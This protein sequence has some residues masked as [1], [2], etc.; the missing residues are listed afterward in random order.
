MK[1]KIFFMCVVAVCLS[2]FAIGETTYKVAAN[3]CGVN[4]QQAY[5]GSGSNYTYSDG[6]VSYDKVS[7][8]DP[9]RTVVCGNEVIFCFD[10]LE[11]KG[12]YELHISYL[13]DSDSRIQS[14]Y[15]DDQVLGKSFKLPNDQV[16]DHVVKIPQELHEDGKIC[17]AIKREQGA[18]AVISTLDVHSNINHPLNPAQLEDFLPELSGYEIMQITSP[19]FSVGGVS[20]TQL[21]LDGTWLFSSELPEEFEKQNDFEKFCKDQIKV[22]GQWVQQGFEVQQGKIAGY[23][24]QFSVPKD[25]NGHRIKLRFE[26]VYSDA[27]VW[28]NGHEAGSYMGGFL[29]FESGYYRTTQAGNQYAVCLCEGRFSR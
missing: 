19:A 24:R 12:I 23:S 8:D 3:N 6:D 9:A 14:L 13:S 10:G 28:V 11:S 26:S 18:N 2:S 22:P 29:P 4:G 5:L 17:V 27:K 1:Q 7:K 16:L 20:L 21:D 15:V 25:W